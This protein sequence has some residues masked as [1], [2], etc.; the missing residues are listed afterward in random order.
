MKKIICIILLSLLLVF[1]LTVSVFADSATITV[2]SVIPKGQ[3][4]N[5]KIDGTGF[6]GY[7]LQ[8]GTTGQEPTLTF[9]TKKESCTKASGGSLFTFSCN[10]TNADTKTW[11]ANITRTNGFTD[12]NYEVKI[13]TLTGGQGYIATSTF[14]VGQPVSRPISLGIDPR[15]FGNDADHN[16]TLSWKPKTPNTKFR[17]ETKIPE[18]PILPGLVS[19]TDSC[20]TAFNVRRGVTPGTFEIIVTQDG[21]ASV[22]GSSLLEIKGIIEKS[23]L[24]TPTPTPPPPPCKEV[25]DPITNKKTNVC[26]T[27]FGEFLTSP[28]DF[29]KQI[30]GIVLS[31]AGGVSVILI[32]LSGYRLISS[33]GNPE[34][35]T[36]AKDQLVSAIIG[37]LFIIF[38]LSILQ[39][40][41]VDILHIPGLSISK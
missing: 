39:I 27:A 38:S 41:G 31:L 11:T 1:N 25:P 5:V 24:S 4:I 32:I 40:I 2:D 9:E 17:V 10:I 8:V 28:G 20:S 13:S 36:A 29:V 34:K 16:V 26:D 3:N 18:Y 14:T 23:P 30:F 19:C 21:D 12:G 37:L 22:R 33:G 7:L 35:L 6:N 15:S